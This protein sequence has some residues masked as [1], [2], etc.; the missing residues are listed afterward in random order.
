[1]KLTADCWPDSAHFRRYIDEMIISVGGISESGALAHDGASRCRMT[2]A[3]ATLLCAKTLATYRGFRFMHALLFSLKDGEGR[4]LLRA[5]RAS[6]WEA[7]P[8]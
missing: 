7:M 4:E 2:T 3:L 8:A 6:Y 1:M 5:M